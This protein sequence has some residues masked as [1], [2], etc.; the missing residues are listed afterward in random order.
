M[1]AAVNRRVRLRDDVLL[2]A[3]GGQVFDLFRDAA[4][5]GLAIR[6]FEKTEFVDARE[7]RERRDEADVR[8]FRRFNRTNAPVVR[9]MN[10]ADFKARAVA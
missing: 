8:A 9:R 6:R 5:L 7:C 10:V 1:A 2:L 3:V 4:I